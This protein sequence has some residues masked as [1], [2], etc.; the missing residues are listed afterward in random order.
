MTPVQFM[1]AELDR[2]HPSQ[3]SVK[4]LAAKARLEFPQ[5]SLA[6][7]RFGAKELIMKNVGM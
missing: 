5:Y 4:I 1:Q 2:L 3:W 7:L 6:V